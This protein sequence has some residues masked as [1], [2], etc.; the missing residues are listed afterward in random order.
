MLTDVEANSNSGTVGSVP[1]LCCVRLNTKSL[2]G[3]VY[4]KKGFV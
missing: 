2:R 1:A 4:L 3:D